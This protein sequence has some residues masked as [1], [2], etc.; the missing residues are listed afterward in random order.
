MVFRKK[1][2]VGTRPEG[3]GFT[4]VEPR[5]WDNPPRS[6]IVSQP[7]LTDVSRQC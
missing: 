1:K 2:A 7:L 3:G 4:S 6:V 5:Q